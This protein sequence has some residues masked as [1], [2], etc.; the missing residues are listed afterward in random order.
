MIVLENYLKIYSIKYTSYNQIPAIT[1]VADKEI[2]DFNSFTYTDDGTS[3]ES[4]SL[5]AF[6][7]LGSN[8]II[9]K[10]IVTKDNRLFP[11]NITEKT[12]DIDLDFFRIHMS[13]NAQCFEIALAKFKETS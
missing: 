1:I 3:T 12:F 10:H 2:D 8:P 4:I 13:G 6:T 7:F 11:V 9:P 5:S